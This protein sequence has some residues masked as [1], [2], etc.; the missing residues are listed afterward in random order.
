MGVFVGGVYTVMPIVWRFW[1]DV[2]Y[3]LNVYIFCQLLDEVRQVGS[4]KTTTNLAGNMVADLV[5]LLREIPNRTL[6][7]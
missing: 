2:A 7:W 1:D 6:S 3:G 5:V 4:M